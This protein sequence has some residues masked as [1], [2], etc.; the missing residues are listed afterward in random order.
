MKTDR[1]LHESDTVRLDEIVMIADAVFGLDHESGSFAAIEFR[2]GMRVEVTEDL[3]VRRSRPTTS[4]P[5]DGKR[6]VIEGKA[7][8]ALD[9]QFAGLIEE[10]RVLGLGVPEL[11]AALL[12]RAE[13]VEAQLAALRIAAVAAQDLRLYGTADQVPRHYVTMALDALAN[14]TPPEGESMLRYSDDLSG[15]SWPKGETTIGEDSAGVAVV[16]RTARRMTIQT[17]PAA[18]DVAPDEI[19]LNGRRYMSAKEK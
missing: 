15:A 9:G 18:P 7:D 8:P 16:G 13:R 2:D 4:D 3:T 12:A 10:A 1:K 19:V 17:G 6:V 14:A 5:S 11:E